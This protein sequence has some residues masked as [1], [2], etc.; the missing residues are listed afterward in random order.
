MTGS[1]VKARTKCKHCNDGTSLCREHTKACIS[2]VRHADVDCGIDKL[3]DIHGRKGRNTAACIR[4]VKRVDVDYG[5]D[6]LANMR[7]GRGRSP[8]RQEKNTT[9]HLKFSPTRKIMRE[10]RIAIPETKNTIP[11]NSSPTRSRTKR[12]CVVTPATSKLVQALANPCTRGESFRAPVKVETKSNRRIDQTFSASTVT[13]AGGSSTSTES[14]S[15]YEDFSDVDADTVSPSNGV[16]SAST[17]GRRRRKPNDGSGFRP[18]PACN[19]IVT[20]GRENFFYSS[21][22]LSVT[23]DYLNTS[24]AIQDRY[25]RYYVNFS[26][27]TVDEWRPL[28]GFLQSYLVYASELT[29]KNFQAVFPWF[30]ELEM[31][32][33]LAQADAFLLDTAITS[34]GHQR[35]YRMSISSLLLLTNIAFMCGLEFTK[36][37]TQQWLR[38]RLQEPEEKLLN[39]GKGI[40]VIV[41]G[42]SLSWS[43]ENLQTLSEMMVKFEDLRNY[44]WEPT[45]TMYLPQDLNVEDSLQLAGNILFPY[46]LREGMM[47]LVVLPKEG[48]VFEDGSNL[49]SRSISPAPTSWSGTTMP[50]NHVAGAMA[51]NVLEHD[52]FKEQLETTMG[53]LLRFETLRQKRVYISRRDTRSIPQTEVRKDWDEY[54]P[55]RR[56]KDIGLGSMPAGDGGLN[57]AIVPASG[58]HRKFEC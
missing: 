50:T 20:V 40:D 56:N 25:G 23:S 35:E 21:E 33:L 47:Q 26:H 49:N 1:T 36:S 31:K 5:I 43:L 57:T 42:T 44:L 48:E 34:Q 18:P 41:E 51:K 12:A 53:N 9:V 22:I 52:D 39:F 29:W 54:R 28:V 6:K 38:A 11:L 8:V 14:T 10:D 19:L 27:H 16:Y 32:E 17:F 45:V 24:A 7:C 4:T 46:L 55:S 15:S 13:S 58:Q 37:R 3:P 30:Y 2:T